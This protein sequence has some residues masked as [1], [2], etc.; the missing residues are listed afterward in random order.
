LTKKQKKYTCQN[1]LTYGTRR[2]NKLMSLE[3]FFINTNCF[4]K[5]T[6]VE[7]KHCSSV[8]LDCGKDQGKC[9]CPKR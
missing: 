4:L 7:D 6:V 3:I 8:A 9:A 2:L 5:T 1:E